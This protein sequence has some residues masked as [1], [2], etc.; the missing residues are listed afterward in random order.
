M[1]EF[2]HGSLNVSEGDGPND[3]AAFVANEIRLVSA[4]ADDEATAAVHALD[5][6]MGHDQQIVE[7]RTHADILPRWRYGRPS[8]AD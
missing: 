6:F 4:R 1:C 3:L 5:T 7:C 2:Q 8:A